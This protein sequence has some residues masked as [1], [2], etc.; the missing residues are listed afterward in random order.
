MYRIVFLVFLGFL[1]ISNLSAQISQ[2]GKPRSFT[3]DGLNSSVRIVKA[4]SIIHLKSAEDSKNGVPNQ[5]G[6]VLKVSY[7]LMNAGTWETLENGDRIWRMA[8]KSD[9]A[10]AIS[11]IFSK[12]NL[13]E[14]ATLFIYSE[15][16]SSL[17]GAFNHLNNNED[18][19]LGTMPVNG[20]VAIVEYYEPYYQ[21][22]AGELEIGS[23]V[24]VFKDIYQIARKAHGYGQSGNCNIN[25]NCPLG[26]NWQDE[27]KSVA[28]ILANG[29]FCTGAIINNVRQDGRPYFLTA[30]HCL[31]GSGS[32]ATWMFV[33]RF[34]SPTCTNEVGPTNYS[35]S[36]ARLRSRNS[37]SDVL[38]LELNT[39]PPASYDIYYA[40]WSRISSATSRTTC[41][42]HPRGD[43]KKIS[44]DNHAPTSVSTFGKPVQFWRVVWDENTTTDPGSSGSPL[45]DNNKR[46][47]GQL[48]GGDASC[49]NLTGGDLYGK[50]NISWERGT[51]YG[52]R[53][54]DW[55]DPDDTNVMTLD[56][57]FIDTSPHYCTSFAEKPEDSKITNVTF[58]SLNNTPGAGCRT[59]STF[60]GLAAR[61]QIGQTYDLSVTAGTCNQDWL[62]RVKVYI[63]WNGDSDFDDEGELVTTSQ[64]IT[65]VFTH[66]AQVT[67][68]D[69]ATDDIVTRMRV[70]CVEATQENPTMIFGA[71]DLYKYG[72]T[73]DYSIIIGEA[74]LSTVKEEK[75]RTEL[76]QNYPNP[77]TGNTTFSFYME[78]EDN[79]LL[80]IYDMLGK[81]IASVTEGAYAEGK[82]MVDYNAGNLKPGTY[83]YKMTS[84]GQTFVRRMLIH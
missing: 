40:G 8:I 12:Y 46:V 42:H 10:M 72:E 35:L 14:N 67:V 70:I 11:L 1:S 47:I 69:H 30:D 50:F 34:E 84:G 41:I 36:G 5:Y 45:F 68:P 56:G 58:E 13:P 38:L 73:Q 44:V 22:G 59:Y 76:F 43:V 66:T 80:E 83:I 15:D 57:S 28:L 54:K 55:L 60:L 51:F 19:V 37:D 21:R 17:I 32:V 20:E 75:N 52:N 49:S 78:R 61:L 39:I 16:R 24:H 77:F 71:C 4:P 7:G 9:G 33:F 31:D 65:G 81:R 53:L 64:A 18:G 79:V 82:H 26:N 29:F 74:A 6:H 23:V 48:Y 3:S 25:I 27:K 2:G 63:D 62:K